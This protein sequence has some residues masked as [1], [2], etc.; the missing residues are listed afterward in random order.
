MVHQTMMV[1]LKCFGGNTEVCDRSHKLYFKY[2]QVDVE[3]NLLTTI[4]QILIKAYLIQ[5]SY[6]K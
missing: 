6:D 1:S 5:N 3:V 4:F 2:S